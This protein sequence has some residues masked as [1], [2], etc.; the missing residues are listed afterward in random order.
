MSGSIDFWFDFSSPYGYMMAERIEALAERH[1]R[2]VNWH[3]F[4]LG[5]IFKHTGGQPLPSQPMKGPYAQVDLARSARF[6]GLPFTMPEAFPV[7]TH[8]AARI[9]YWLHVHKP[10]LGKDFALAAFRTYFVDGRDI[11]Q[12]DVLQ[13]V[14]AHLGVTAEQ[15][16]EATSDEAVKSRLREV[17]DTAIASG[18]FGSPFVIIDGEP[19]W[20]VDRLP[21]IDHWLE[22]GGF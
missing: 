9:Y 3:P 18:V 12:M 17:C 7:S 14:C 2:E 16:A 11:S 1:D 10:E 8:Q 19:F 20:G 21:Q 6:L 4:L 22:D 15:V 5:A 13:D